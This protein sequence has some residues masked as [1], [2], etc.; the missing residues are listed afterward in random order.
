MGRISAE[1]ITPYPPGVPA[2]APGER[3]TQP[4]VDYLTGFIDA[5]GFVEGAVDQSLQRLRVVA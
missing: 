1:L 4:L 2:A 3:Y 5:A